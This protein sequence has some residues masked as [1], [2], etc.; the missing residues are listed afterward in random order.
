MTTFHARLR[1]ANGTSVG[2]DI[3][4]R[5]LADARQGAEAYAAREDMSVDTFGH[6]PAF[7]R[8]RRSQGHRIIEVLTLDGYRPF[9][10]VA[11]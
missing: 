2:I 5:T 11:S 10:G 7:L 4:A 6:T 9:A 3:D 8:V 1:G